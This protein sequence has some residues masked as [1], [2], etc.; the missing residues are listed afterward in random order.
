MW[1]KKLAE[2]FDSVYT[3]EPN[4]LLFKCLTANTQECLNVWS[5]CAALGNERG[6]V[7]V[8]HPEKPLNMGAYYVH[9][10]E[11]KTPTL[12]IDDLALENVDLI[13][14]DIEGYELFALQGAVDTLQK[15]S[16]VVVVEWH[17]NQFERYGYKRNAITN[18]LKVF[19]YEPR[20][21]RNGRDQ[22]FLRV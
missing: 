1:A 16:P 7:N 17:E 9:E 11:G 15:W 14:L 5:Y 6:C 4:P 22:L 19:G 13:F 3:F 10:G 2:R 18:F 12:K 20:P 21:L 8:D